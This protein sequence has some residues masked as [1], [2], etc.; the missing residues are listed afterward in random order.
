MTRKCE[1][2]FSFNP[3]LW[4]RQAYQMRRFVRAYATVSSP[5]KATGQFAVV[6]MPWLGT[7]VPWF[8]IAVGLIL[9]ATGSRISFIIDGLPFG[10]NPVRFRVVLLCIRSVL[11]TLNRQFEILELRAAGNTSLK[12]DEVEMVARLAKLNAVWAMRGEMQE[13]GRFDYTERITSQLTLSACAIRLF[14]ERRKFDCVIVPGGI[15]GSSGLW[16]RFAHANGTRLASFDS[17]GRGI[18]TVAAN[19]IA[20]QLQD[21]PRAFNLLKAGISA[22]GQ[23]SFARDAALAELQR[24]RSGTDQFSS[25]L[26]RTAKLDLRFHGAVLLALNSSWDS[27]ALGLHQ[28]FENSAQ[29][30]VGTVRCLLERTKAQIVVRQHPAERF[31]AG[32][33]SD[34]YGRLLRESFSDDPRVTFVAAADPV[35]SYD[36]LD[37]AAAVIVYTS[38]FGIEA[39]IQGKVV[40]TPSSS[41]Y[42][43]LGFV[44]RAESL[45]QYNDQIVDAVEGRYTV[46]EQMKSDALMCYYLTQCCNWIHT[47]LSPEGYEDWI[48]MSPSDLLKHE[49]VRI[50]YSAL[51]DNVPTAFLMHSAKVQDTLRPAMP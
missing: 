30:V 13:R 21:I 25:Q 22:R 24:R 34:D 45:D 3:L 14:L 5:T 43:E 20:S 18:V 31:Q 37:E 29:W 32:R 51:R 42:S 40:V 15:Y 36:L 2:R 26:R 27:A 47:P 16:A 12:P 11:G 9:A 49:G 35:N 39:A 1:L 23:W 41:Y 28:V 33:S 46:S 44:W 6:V 10:V 7:A 50:T 17:G 4:I 8:S 48:R 38:T 19:G